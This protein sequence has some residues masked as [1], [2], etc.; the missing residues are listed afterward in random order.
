MA[1]TY[2]IQPVL[3]RINDAVINP[4][5]AVLFIIAF[6]SF[7]WGIVRFIAN[8]EN[9]SERSVGKQ[10]M[11]W[12]VVGM[13]IMMGVFFIINIIVNTF[14][15]ETRDGTNPAETVIPIWEI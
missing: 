7:V 2:A 10:N 13:V 8:N 4:L 14:D 6:A 3:E 15:L 11:I 12:G 5:I 9:E 1:A